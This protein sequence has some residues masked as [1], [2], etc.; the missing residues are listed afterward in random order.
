MSAVP[1]A[2]APLSRRAIARAL[3]DAL[4]AQKPGLPLA[5]SEEHAPAPVSARTLADA[6]ALPGAVVELSALPGAGAL[7]CGLLL[8]R[9]AQAH[10]IGRGHSRHL[11][12][13]DPTRTLCAPA[14]A[15]LGV[16]LKDLIVLQPDA[17]RLLRIAVRAQRSGVFSAMMIDASGL[18]D[19]SRLDVPVR[20]LALACE[21]SGGLCV[22]V[23]SSRARRAVP[24]PTAARALVE[25]LSPQ[26]LSVRFVKH[27]H[28][29]AHPLRVRVA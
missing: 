5:L 1:V 25:A 17:E 19:L 21:D 7:T 4:R 28:G 16:P 10:A 13:V 20:R 22:L 26:E 9:A 23:T 6:L 18:L 11:C 2:T 12:I 15:A 24:L 27:K 14:V 3:V 29:V 8:L